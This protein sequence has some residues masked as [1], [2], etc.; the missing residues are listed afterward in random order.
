MKRLLIILLVL[1]TYVN[2]GT[3]CAQ[4]HCTSPSRHHSYTS[5]G[6]VVSTPSYGFGSTSMYSNS[7]SRRNYYSTAPMQVANGSIKTIASS[8]KGG[9]LLNDLANNIPSQRIRSR[10]N[11]MAPPTDTEEFPIGDGWDVALLLAV[12]CVGYVVRRYLSVRRMKG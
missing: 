9:V 10:Q 8:I 4:I 7:I 6:G 11:T 5:G 2:R 3:I 1:C 12:L